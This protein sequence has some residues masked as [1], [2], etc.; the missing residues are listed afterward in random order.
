LPGPLQAYPQE[1]LE[2]RAGDTTRRELRA[3]YNRA[4]DAVGA[5]ACAELRA[6]PERVRA[7][8]DA[9]Y[10]YKVRERL[11]SGQN[12]SE[13]LAHSRIPKLAVPHF[14]DWGEL[15]H[16]ILTENLPGSF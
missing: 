1:A 8:T 6:W 2:E 12:Y 3:A 14:Q 13:S 16:F 11:V 9:T 15:L 5:E 7:A 10:S 4:L